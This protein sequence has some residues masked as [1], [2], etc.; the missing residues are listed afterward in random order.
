[1]LFS[2]L[3]EDDTGTSITN[4]SENLATLVQFHFQLEEPIR[5][6]EY[7]P[8]HNLPE[9]KKKQLMFRESLSEIFYSQNGQNYHSPQWKHFKREQFETLVHCSI[10]MNGYQTL[11]KIR[12]KTA[13]EHGQDEFRRGCSD[14]VNDRKVRDYPP[15]S[16]AYLKGFRYAIHQ[17][18]QRN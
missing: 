1:V 4:C 14:A 10:S 2:D 17:L 18:S 12:L 9:R 3:N 6:F 13:F 11:K 8:Y 5:W 16:Q 15:H 7:Y